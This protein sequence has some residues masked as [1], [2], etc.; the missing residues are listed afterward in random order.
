MSYVKIVNKI[1]SLLT[2]VT[3]LISFGF[4]KDDTQT[5]L[6]EQNERSN[7]IALTFDDGPHPKITNDIL[8]TLEK[9][10]IKA[11]FFVIGKNVDLYQ[12]QL[13]KIHELG[14][15]IGNHTNS[16]KQLTS[17]SKDEVAKEIKLCHDKVLR[18]TG[19]QMKVFRP[20]CG[21]I[22]KSIHEII[23][24]MGYQE[25]LWSIDTH[26]WSHETTENILK[27]VSKNVIGGDIVL[28][29][30]YISGKY[31][32]VDVLNILIP[33]LLEQGYEFVTISELIN[34]YPPA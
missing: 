17:L 5:C 3:M 32:T 10:N 18:L 24:K 25:V 20:P 7:K 15:E 2:I 33:M 6:Y 21:K 31:S 1:V 9:Y 13:I 22:N 34:K 28:F 23:N 26:D 8:E 12:N 14:H 29:H 4:I 19:V 11:T 27:N 16:H 30:D